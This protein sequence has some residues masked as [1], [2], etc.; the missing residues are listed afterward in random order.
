MD[1]Q[2]F[3]PWIVSGGMG[4]LG[5]GAW[6]RAKRLAKAPGMAMIQGD[7]GVIRDQV[8]VIA[9]P[10]VPAEQ[11]Y[12]G[13][14]QKQIPV[15]QTK[16][17]IVPSAYDLMDV[18]RRP[19]LS[20]GKVFL[21]VDCDGQHITCDA[22]NELVHGAFNASTGRGKTIT[23]RGLETQ[24]LKLGHEVLHADIKFS[25]VDERGNDSRPI[26]KALL[27]QGEVN[28]AGKM[29][30]HLMMREDHICYML[31]WLSGPELTRRLAMYNR[32]DH[33]YGTFFLFLEE[34]AYLVGKYKEMGKLIAQLLVVGRSVGIKVFCVAQNFQV[35]NLKLNSGMREN[36]DSAWFL[37]GDTN[38]GAALLDIS[39]HALKSMLFQNQIQLG[40]GVTIFRNNFV[41]YE[42]RVMRTGMA[43]NDFVYHLLGRA[44]GFL[45][46]EEILPTFGD[47]PDSLP[48]D[49]KRALA[50]WEDG[51]RGPRALERALGCTYYRA[52][53][54]CSEL[55]KRGLVEPD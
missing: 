17:I 37:G 45:L 36:F 51:V 47:D 38:S 41:A 33:S 11:P 20:N 40:K 12:E 54:L 15:M 43:S 19:A 1:I 2:A 13:A 18:V 10:V 50:A 39:E 4:L 21:G 34:L 42:P 46:P 5:L 6:Y 32:G 49:L 25:L 27:G 26:A 44:D 16:R 55:T 30:P 22:S 7:S 8:P 3:V 53:Q 9:D 24:L 14:G 23:V 48:E 29:L 52:V 31:E 28:M 35:Q